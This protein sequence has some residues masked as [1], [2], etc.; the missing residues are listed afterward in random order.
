VRRVRSRLRLRLLL[1][2]IQRVSSAR[3]IALL[4]KKSWKFYGWRNLLQSQHRNLRLRCISLI[5]NDMYISTSS[6]EDIWFSSILVCD[7][8]G[9]VV[10][11]NITLLAFGKDLSFLRRFVDLCIGSRE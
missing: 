5:G 2:S 8:F 7:L 10:V 4:V 9:I 11:W 1:L 3:S 6:E